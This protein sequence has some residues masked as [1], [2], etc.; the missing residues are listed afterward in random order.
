MSTAF[1]IN[2][3]GENI[4]NANLNSLIRNPR[5]FFQQRSCA[6][7]ISFS[8]PAVTSG[9][10]NTANAPPPFDI[11]LVNSRRFVENFS[12]N[13]FPAVPLHVLP[14]LQRITT[15]TTVVSQRTT[16]PISTYSSHVTQ[17]FP[18]SEPP[19]SMESRGTVFYCN[20]CSQAAP[21]STGIN[22]TS[23][24]QSPLS[25]NAPPFTPTMGQASP[26]ALAGLTV[27]DLAQLLAASKKP[28]FQSGNCLNTSTTY[29]DG[30][31]GLIRLKKL[32]N[33]YRRRQTFV[34]ENARCRE[35]G[36]RPCRVCVLWH[37]VPRRC[38]NAGAEVLPITRCGKCPLTQI[39]SPAL[40]KHNS[41]NIINCSALISTLVGVFRSLH[42][43]QHLPSAA[44]LGQAVP[45][46]QPNLREPW[47]KHTFKN[48]W[49]CPTLLEFNDWLKEKVEAHGMT[50][51]T[52]LKPKSD[53]NSSAITKKKTAL[54]VFASTSKAD[55][56]TVG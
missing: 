43:V 11:S 14:T 40:K 46:L 21:F 51:I 33:S 34:F 28:N 27:Q 29:F 8:I 12:S 55:T 54:K 56:A 9:L 42:Y 45:K 49:S 20:P 7:G 35:S 18:T 15:I 30:L 10:D 5:P 41:E 24:Q 2:P 32:C 6:A 25:I 39:E 23:C 31:S 13:P 17:I 47:A 16:A 36:D 53:G 37:Y 19:V 4:K 44:V 1:L 50:K 38:T 22:T 52:S 26:I 3:E 48:K